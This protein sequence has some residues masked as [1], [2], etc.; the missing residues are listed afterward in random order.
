M[1]KFSNIRND[2]TMVTYPRKDHKK[3]PGW[4]S[5]HQSTSSPSV[6]TNAFTPIWP[7]VPVQ[8]RG[9]PEKEEATTS[10]APSQKYLRDSIPNMMPSTVS[11][12]MR[13]VMERVIESTTPLSNS[14]YKDQ[15]RKK[16][17][18]VRRLVELLGTEIMTANGDTN[19]WF[20]FQKSQHGLSVRVEEVRE[21]PNIEGYRNKC[22]FAIG[23]NPETRRLTVGFKLDPR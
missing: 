5:Y 11:P 15:V 19:N 3:I 1:D 17:G 14:S 7:A 13:A 23:L 4:D 8:E 21:S 20:E 9:L 22:E 16:A 2:S 18:E 6:Q 10:S 12:G